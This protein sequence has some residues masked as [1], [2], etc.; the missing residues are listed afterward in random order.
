[1]K[2]LSRTLRPALTTLVVSLFAGGASGWATATSGAG[3]ST[4]DIHIELSASGPQPHVVWISRKGGFTLRN[5]TAEILPASVEIDGVEAP[6]TWQHKPELDTI[7]PSHT[8]FVYE[9]ASPHLRLRWEWQA[10]A[11]FG[12]IEHR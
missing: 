10:R 2:M 4:S 1:M 8:V 11:P 3:V 6:V 12:P 9:S 7:E 5:R